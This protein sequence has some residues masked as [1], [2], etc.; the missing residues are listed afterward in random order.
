MRGRVGWKVKKTGNFAV[1]KNFLHC[2]ENQTVVRSE[3]IFKY[4]DVNFQVLG[5]KFPSTWKKISKY[6]KK[7]FQVL[8]KIFPSTWKFTSEY[9]EF[10]RMLRCVGFLL[11]RKSVGSVVWSMKCMTQSG[12]RF[13]VC[14]DHEAGG[15]W[16]A[17]CGNAN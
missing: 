17:S 16:F 4:W 12:W 5:R 14:C 11:L 9:L 1:A 6:L 3:E 8:E 10:F 2:A 7:N 15:V 13:P